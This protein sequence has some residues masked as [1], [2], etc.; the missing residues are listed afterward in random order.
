MDFGEVRNFPKVLF[1]ADPNQIQ[2]NSTLPILI[3]SR[4]FDFTFRYKK[5]RAYALAIY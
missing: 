4:M 1:R 2:I 5:A 3:I